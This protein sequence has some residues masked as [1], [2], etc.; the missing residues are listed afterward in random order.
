MKS[1]YVGIDI[2]KQ[3]A[4]VGIDEN[5]RIL[6]KHVMPIVGNE[7]DLNSLID[8]IRDL[9]LYEGEYIPYVGIERPLGLGGN[10]ATA[11]LTMGMG[12]G[13]LVG[14]LHSFGI[15]YTKIPPN[16]WTK[17]IHKGLNKTLKA[18]ERS[19]IIVQQL[20]PLVDLRN[21]PKCKNPHEGLIDA[22][23]IAEYVR[24]ANV[25]KNN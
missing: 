19:K 13:Y 2:G 15:S 23:L 4:I 6:L 5:K 20:F 24:R 9:K 16:V 21:T 17:E 8:I 11:T 1:L 18:K 10:A 22:L 25:N 12:F 14:I 7:Y 3:G